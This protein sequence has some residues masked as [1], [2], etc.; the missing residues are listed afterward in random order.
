MQSAVANIADVS[1]VRDSPRNHRG[2]F[3][4]TGVG[5]VTERAQTQERTGL[6]QTGDLFF[7]FVEIKILK[8]PTWCW[9]TCTALSVTRISHKKRHERLSRD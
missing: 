4:T 2:E 6:I 5:N 7:V 9:A 1:N 3:G 8:R